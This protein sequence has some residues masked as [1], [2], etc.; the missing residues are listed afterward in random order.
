MPELPDIEA[1]LA[2]LRRRVVG[3][4]VVSIR[5]RSVFL[6]RSISP[7]LSDLEGMLVRD[8]WR[9]GKRIVIAFE[10][11]G[12]E[13]FLVLHLM[14]AGRLQWGKRR[15]GLPGKRGLCA[16]DFEDGT[17]LLTEASKMKRAS[18]YVVRSRAEVDDHDP[19]GLEVLSAGVVEFATILRSR[20]H[21]LKRSLTDPHLFAGIGGAYADEIM[22]RARLS[23]IVWTQ[24]LKDDEVERL[25]RAAQ[26][27]LLEWSQRIQEQTGDGWPVVTAFREEMAVHGKYRDACPVCGDPV[28]RIVYAENETNYCA[29]C[30]TGG[31]IL[32][33]RSLSRLLKDDWPRTIDE[34]ESQRRGS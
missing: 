31:R 17:L 5:L 6:V 26:D 25:F 21:T 11:D 9:I 2:A 19:G 27:V 8:V 22:H 7:P 4:R 10:S 13:R 12:E 32:A 29:T 33:D 1:Y 15:A 23:P 18:L 3:R 34:L 20:N 24:R 16:F 30:Q 14:I 28:Q